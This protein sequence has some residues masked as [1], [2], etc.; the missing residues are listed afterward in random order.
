M[1]DHII[2]VAERLFYNEGIRAV[3]V[4]RIIAEADIAK[5]TL[6]K[7]FRTKDDLI[8]ACLQTRHER[9]VGALQDYT[10][11]S[12][13]RGPLRCLAAF[14][15][16][17]QNVEG[18]GF[19][20]CAFLIALA[21]FEFSPRVLAVTREHKDALRGI[22][23]SLLDEDDIARDVKAAQLALIYDGALAGVAVRRDPD[24]VTLAR[25]CALLILG[26]SDEKL[27]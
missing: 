5:A 18:G 17:R 2:S 20:G 4:D 14:D 6:Y 10:A 7:Y 22:F 15:R 19:R 26:S 21:E 3:G 13:Y 16:L 8:E 9:V 23:R 12:A 24:V 27:H 1:R 11:N 25:D